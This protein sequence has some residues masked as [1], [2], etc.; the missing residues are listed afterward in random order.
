MAVDVLGSHVAR[1][2]VAMVLALWDCESLYCIG[3]DL[4]Y[5]YQLY[6]E[7]WWEIR[8]SVYVYLPKINSYNEVNGLNNP[9]VSYTTRFLRLP[10]ADH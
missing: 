8:T 9:N 4:K 7:K 5:S 3:K 1:A 6:V 2:S 10:G